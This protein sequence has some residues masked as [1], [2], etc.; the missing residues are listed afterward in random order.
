MRARLWRLGESDVACLPDGIYSRNEQTTMQYG[1]ESHI[2]IPLGGLGASD[3]LLLAVQIANLIGRSNVDNIV[4]SWQH[5]ILVIAGRL[6]CG[7][8]LSSSL[9]AAF[10]SCTR[11]PGWT[12]TK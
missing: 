3:I 8:V 2:D 6:C 1:L 10:S 11:S 5:G 7:A 12:Y 4:L 9:P